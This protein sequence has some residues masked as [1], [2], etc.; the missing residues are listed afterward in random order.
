MADQG[1][2]PGEPEAL[3]CVSDWDA[4]YYDVDIPNSSVDKASGFLRIRFVSVGD[5]LHAGGP[6]PGPSPPQNQPSQ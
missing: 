1:G 4:A 2:N 5:F 6:A 3:E